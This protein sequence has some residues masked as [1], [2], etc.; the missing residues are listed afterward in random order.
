RQAVVSF[1]AAAFLMFGLRVW[2]VTHTWRD[3]DRW[4]TEFRQASAVIAPGARL[5]VVAAELP[6]PEDFPSAPRLLAKL[7][8]F[9]FIHMA[10]LAVMDRAAFFPYLFTGWT[11]IDVAPRNETVSQRQAVPA[12][13]EELTK[14]ADPEQVNSLDIDANFLGERPYWRNW[15]ETFD[16]VLWIDFSKAQKPELGQ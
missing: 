1:A 7:E 14:S 13:P 5:L 2:T 9:P 3:Y 11:T 8:S 6:K 15:P 12:T 16:F 4:F 10:A